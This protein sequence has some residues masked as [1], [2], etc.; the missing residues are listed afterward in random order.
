[1]FR[2][3]IALA[4]ADLTRCSDGN[5]IASRLVIQFHPERAT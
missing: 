3:N 5:G 1:M 2:R 4:I